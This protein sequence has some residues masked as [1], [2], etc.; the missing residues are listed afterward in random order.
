MC[1]VCFKACL[2][3]A[4]VQEAEGRFGFPIDNTIGVCDRPCSMRAAKLPSS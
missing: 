4:D 1:S 2:G 3:G